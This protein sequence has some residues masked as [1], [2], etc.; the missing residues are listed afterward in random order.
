M[1]DSSNENKDTKTQCKKK[2]F[3]FKAFVTWNGLSSGLIIATSGIILYI[4]P[5]G[6][7]IFGKIWHLFGLNLRN[8][9]TIHTNFTVL[10]II[11]AGLHLYLNW[12]IFLSY[13]KDKIK[14]TFKIRLELAFSF[15]LS[16]GIFTCIILELPPFENIMNLGQELSQGWL[17]T[18]EDDNQNNE[19]ANDDKTE[20]RVTEKTEKTEEKTEADKDE[21]KRREEKLKELAAL[22]AKPPEKIWRFSECDNEECE[23]TGCTLECEAV[24]DA[25]EWGELTIADYCHLY[26]IKLVDAYKK[27][28]R[29]KIAK[30]EDDDS[31]S[32][33]AMNYD[34]E[35]KDIYAIIKGK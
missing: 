3:S 8:W 21:V 12:R 19:I 27:L 1:S 10:F 4:A 25:L 32:D 17:V 15:L 30:F 20:E 23:E 9:Q 29:N 11:F 24:K 13:L 2:K 6:G 18:D 28:Y 33:I 35:P 16:A 7:E 31:I 26:K 34:K 22:D 14:K 5:P